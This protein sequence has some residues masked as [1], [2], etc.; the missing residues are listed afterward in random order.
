MA[1]EID[2]NSGDRIPTR[3]S[4]PLMLWSTCA[5]WIAGVGA[6]AGT[7]GPADGVD[8]FAMT[9]PEMTGVFPI[10]GGTG[11]FASTASAPT[12]AAAGNETGVD[13]FVVLCVLAVGVCCCSFALCP[14]PPGW[15]VPVGFGVSAAA[16]EGALFWVF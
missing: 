16:R 3:I 9:A 4:V 15:P 5:L 14:L 10:A 1:I 11:V 13:G 2:P 12:L 8:S 7:C 6:A